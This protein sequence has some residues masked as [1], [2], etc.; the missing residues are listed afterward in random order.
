M[1]K[2]QL[3]VIITLVT[4]LII[5]A[6]GVF[7]FYEAEDVSPPVDTPALVSETDRGSG[8]K[9]EDASG[10]NLVRIYS[11]IIG[12]E[13]AQVTI[14]EFFDPSCEACRAF[15]PYV[16]QILNQYPDDVRVVLR[17]AAF[18]QGSDE[19]VKILEAARLQDM[20]IPVLEILLEKQPQWA[21]H[22]AP[23]LDKAWKFAGNAG[24]DLAKA[25][26]D[27][28][29]PEIEELLK[30]EADDIKSVGIRG[31]PTLFVNGRLLRSLSPK[32][33]RDAVEK[34]IE[35]GKADTR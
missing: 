5:F 30:Q 33:L 21:V 22:G 10:Q 6:I 15:H 8:L 28:R 23:Q 20:F 16:K 13:D 24:L 32:H 12:R 11:P 26:N 3:A 7:F 4:A 9:T 29:N 1:I 34:E 25:K 17:Y 35:T 31:T 19:A 27:A 2:Q 18:H 14:V